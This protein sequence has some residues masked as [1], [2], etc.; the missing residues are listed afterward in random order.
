MRII[1]GKLKGR[2]IKGYDI[3]GTRPTMD[4]VKESIFSSIQEYIPGSTVLDL[5]SGSGNLGFE[6]ISNYADI[7]YFVDKNK[8]CIKLIDD[9]IKLFNI[10]NACTYNMDYMDALIKL[11][12][13]K[14]DVIFLDPPY[15]YNDYIDIS[16]DY[17]IKNHMINSDGIIVCEFDK[18]I[19][20]NY[21][22]LDIIK[23]KKY[24]DK[25]VIVFKKK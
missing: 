3:E 16:I 10:D 8:E 23:N 13:V 25:F 11:K 15:K 5:F 2:I 17:M 7:C 22:E 21:E 4:R 9:N 14:F 24:G 20:T 12:D 1:S 18:E 6:S 19:K